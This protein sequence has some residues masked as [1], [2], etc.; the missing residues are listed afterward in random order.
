ML[1]RFPSSKVYRAPSSTIE[2]PQR[3]CQFFFV[4]ER[5]CSSHGTE[6]S[7]LVV[8]GVALPLGFVPSYTLHWVVFFLLA[9][10]WVDPGRNA[11]QSAE[12]RC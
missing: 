10:A 12:Q 4:A 3:S 5:G 6:L 1:K 7:G 9:A 8:I 11:L 2:L